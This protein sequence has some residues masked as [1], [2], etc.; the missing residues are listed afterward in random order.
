MSINELCMLV[1]LYLT[2]NIK[3][4]TISHAKCVFVVDSVLSCGKNMRYMSNFVL[5][6]HVL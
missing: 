4:Y 2:V 3:W 1:G 6:I 5:H